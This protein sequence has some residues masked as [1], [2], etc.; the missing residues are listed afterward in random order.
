MAKIDLDSLNIDE[1]A[2]L[3]ERVTEKLAEKVA[4]RQLEL[5]AEL[6]RLS[7][8]GKSGKKAQTAPVAKPKKNAVPPQEEP[9]AD[10]AAE[11]A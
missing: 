5:E 7:Q 3:R 9:V 4:A 10:A 1:L 11:A 2:A 6:E 8:F